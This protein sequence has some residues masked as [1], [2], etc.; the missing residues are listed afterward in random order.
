MKA[1]PRWQYFGALTLAGMLSLLASYVGLMTFLRGGFPR[2][3]PGSYVL[4]GLAP[5]AAFPLFALSAA[6]W[7]M[8]AFAMWA[9]G[10]AYSLA[11][12][13]ANA[14]EFAGS[15]GNYVGL[16]AACLFD[17]MAIILWVTAWLVHFGAGIYASKRNAESGIA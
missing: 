15:F 9:L 2:G 8:C 1:G 7:K 17:R 14:R 12:F 3:F 11:L 16:L 6:S 10:P 5:L 13:E 4:I